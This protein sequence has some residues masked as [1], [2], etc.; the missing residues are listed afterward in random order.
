MVWTDKTIQTTGLGQQKRRTM[1]LDGAFMDQ[2]AQCPT[3]A[4]SPP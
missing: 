4:E 2:T 1:L 3:T